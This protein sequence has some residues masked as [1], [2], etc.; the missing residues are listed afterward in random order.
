MDL[1]LAESVPDHSSIW[2]FRNQLMKKQLLE[3]LLSQI[4]GDLAKQGI[5]VSQ[6]SVGQEKTIY[7]F[8]M[9]INTDENGLIKQVSDTAGNV[10]DSKEL[11]K[12]LEF[13]E[14][15]SVRKVY[16]DSAYANGKNE[17]KLG[18]ENNK[19]LHRAYRNKPLTREQKRASCLIMHLRA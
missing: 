13:K 1:S 14:G 5:S 7:A 9:Q 4:N 12:L 18:A 10:H 17:E 6:G 3:V 11:E 15:K 16:A 8:K 19:I 2:R